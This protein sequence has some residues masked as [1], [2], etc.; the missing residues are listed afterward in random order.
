MKTTYLLLVA[1]MLL[2]MPSCTEWLKE[3]PQDR[4]SAE[5]YYDGDASLVAGA[6]GCYLPLANSDG[7]YK[8]NF[9]IQVDAYADCG[10]ASQGGNNSA[11]QFTEGQL[12]ADHARIKG[13]WREH[14]SAIA[15]CNTFIYRVEHQSRN[16]K[17]QALKNRTLGEARFIRALLYFNLV[18]CFGEVPL[19]EKRVTDYQNETHIPVSR[20]K[21][22][23]DFIIQDLIFAE[24]NCWNYDETRGEFT[25]H[26]GRVTSLAA[27]A[28]LAKVY[29]HIAS[30]VR[31]AYTPGFND[32]GVTGICDGYKNGYEASDARK[33]YE[34][35]EQAC[36]RGLAHPDFYLE[37]V[38]KDLWDIKNR[39]SK[40][41]L[42]STQY[43][44]QAGY[45]GKLPSQF[46]PKDCKYGAA[47][48]T[49]N[50]IQAIF[51]PFLAVRGE[52]PTG[53]TL[54]LDTAD[55][56]YRHGLLLEIPYWSR[57]DSIMRFEYF[58]ST[59]TKPTKVDASYYLWT[60]LNNTSPVFV[61]K[62]YKGEVKYYN[63]CV[64]YAKYQDPESPDQNSSRTGFPILRSVDLCLLLGEAKAELSGNP[65]DGFAA[66]N[67]AR[68]RTRDEGRIELSDEYIDT[69]PGETKMDR[70]REYVMRERLMEFFGEADRYFTLQRMGA[71]IRK[72]N[73]V[74]DKATCDKPDAKKKRNLESKYYW[75]PIPNDEINS[76]NMISENA[77][78]Y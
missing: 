38:W 63:M 12:D 19:R 23:Y 72:C 54:P 5:N 68:D 74:A 1:A 6:S 2:V 61:R 65:S 36:V 76:N 71:Y 27:T 25:N 75:W 48:S 51:R 40:E 29:M 37:P 15:R 46:L 55:L 39:F 26:K 62:N 8:S 66:F 28:L 64:H 9:P 11:Q 21:D 18:R 35:C 69:F 17:D 50:G 13:L 4:Y 30:S 49:S 44:G 78:G 22:I 10:F 33:Y 43:A 52:N 14:Y 53:L 73:L 56:R 24:T 45:Y 70:F 16:I 7:L 57:P 3:V 41:F 42:F 31:V 67:M 58:K 34:L 47:G 77:P 60:K 20:R 32:M 59:E